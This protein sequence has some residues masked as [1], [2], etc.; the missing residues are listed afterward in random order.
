[1]NRFQ[2]ARACGFTLIELMLAVVG[3]SVVLGAVY[4]SYRSSAAQYYQQEQE[5]AIQDALRL[6]GEH[7]KNDLRNVGR[8]TVANGTM[9]A[10]YRDVGLCRTTVVP[11]A[12]ELIEN[13]N[14]GLPLNMTSSPNSLVPDRLRL[15]VDDSNAIPLI[16]SR[17][18]GSSVY[19][20]PQDQEPSQEAKTLLTDAEKNRFLAMY[21]AGSFLYLVDPVGRKSDLVPIKSVQILTGEP[22]I[23][24]SQPTCLNVSQCDG[25][26]RVNPVRLVEYAVVADANDASRTSLVKRSLHAETLQ[27]LPNSEVILADYVVNLQVYGEYDSRAVGAL[28]SNLLIDTN[29]ADD[30]GNWPGATQESS[31]MNQRPE[32]LRA[33]NVLLAVRSSREDPRFQVTSDRNATNRVPGD[34]IWYDLDGQLSTG[35]ARVVAVLSRVETPN[36]YRGMH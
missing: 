12:I 20:A 6:A 31:V 25:S 32:R 35:L 33:L 24:L 17:V 36:L 22:V 14:S 10:Q 3:V 4:L 19:I 7:L 9:D 11:S 1:M 30:L 15:M 2:R 34:R 28:N 21:K 26:C 18:M 13:D 16:T 5:R 8:L 29:P 23:E 27:P